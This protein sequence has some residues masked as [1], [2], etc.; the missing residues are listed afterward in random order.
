MCIGVSTPP[1]KHQPPLSCQA[2]SPP[3]KSANCLSAP[4]FLGSSP[5]ILVFRDPPPLKVGSFSE[6]SII[7][8]DLLIVTK[9]VG[10]F[11]NLNSDL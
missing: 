9:F 1:Q 3:L 2:P 8:S 4:P 6:P 10:K 5:S 11:P 7:P